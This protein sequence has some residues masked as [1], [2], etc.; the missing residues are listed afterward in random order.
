MIGTPTD[1]SKKD[2]KSEDLD[3]EPW[4][5]KN[6]HEEFKDNL[7]DNNINEWSLKNHLKE[8]LIEIMELKHNMEAQVTTLAWSLK[9]EEQKMGLFYLMLTFTILPLLW[10]SIYFVYDC[11]LCFNALLG[12]G[13]LWIA[14]NLLYFIGNHL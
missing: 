4:E 2:E 14:K 7:K 11:W 3:E 8:G 6:P 9:L 5:L 1:E 12:G 10:S 13:S